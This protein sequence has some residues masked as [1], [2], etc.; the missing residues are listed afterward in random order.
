MKIYQVDAFTNQPFK[1]NPAGVCL[2]DDERPDE[3]MRAV[4][5]EMN[6]SETA[7]LLAQPGGLTLRWFTPTREVSLCGH[8]TLATAQVLWEEQ[9]R[10]LREELEFDTNSGRLTA[11][12]DGGFILL[13]F[14]ARFATPTEENQAVNRALGIVP[15]CTSKNSSPKGD[16]FLLEVESESIV[17]A[18]APNFG[19]LGNS[20]IRSVIVTSPSAMPA[21]DFVSRYFA[22]GVGV[23]EDPVTGVAHCYLAPYW[24][25]RLNKRTLVGLQASKR[26]GVVGCEW[27][28]DRVV[29]RG[30]AVTVIK[31]E[32]VA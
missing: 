24:G 19:E 14:P 25:A 13:D 5:Q 30:Q 7:F 10:D 9:G 28:G 29:L 27:K 22:P 20:G 1:G 3:W 21:Y 17:R 4:A 15:T 31:G 11:G 12:W 2:L 32:L 23:Q 26:T 8:A 18:M 6:L 16:V